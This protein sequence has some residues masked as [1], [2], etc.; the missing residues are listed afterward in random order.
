M[1]IVS[2]KI[3]SVDMPDSLIF[4]GESVFG[5]C[6]SLEEVICSKNLTEL[7]ETFANCSNL[8]TFYIPP[9]S[10]LT[11]IGDY[12]FKNCPLVKIEIPA[13]V[14]EIG[15]EA[16]SGSLNK[17]TFSKDS[18]LKKIG[19]A[20]FQ[21]C[22]FE[23]VTLPASLEE[24]GN[25]IFC[26]CDRLEKISFEKNA[27][28]TKI[29]IGAFS[30]C[31]KLKEVDIPEN[32]TE[33]GDVLFVIVYEEGYGYAPIKK[34]NIKG[35]KI[36]KISKESFKGL[37]KKGTI[38]VPKKCKKKYTKMFKKQKWYKKTMKIKAMK[39]I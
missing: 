26:H 35:G 30:N 9:S 21:Y 3:K 28:I 15:K 19:N 38:T 20:A 23:R 24:I 33:I 32:V 29:P 12:T 14:T 7:K 1:G 18:R 2:C 37:V 17:L 16:F 13:S 25:G 31:M 36:K 10:Q 4:L 34:I 22:G 6:E 11:R 27:K 5:W 39:K 8:K